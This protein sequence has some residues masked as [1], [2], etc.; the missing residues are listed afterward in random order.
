DMPLRRRNSLL[1]RIY[2]SNIEIKH[3]N[4]KAIITLYVINTQKRTLY[5]RYMNSKRFFES[6]KFNILNL[7]KKYFEYRIQILKYKLTES[8]L[9][10]KFILRRTKALQF[11]FEF[12][13]KIINYFNLSFNE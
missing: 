6:L 4:N 10:N 7:Q 3:T 1:R 13:N 8:F 2:V 5:K 12:L 11:T 9:N